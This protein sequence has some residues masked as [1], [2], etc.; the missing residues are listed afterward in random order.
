MDP[1]RAPN[2]P[3]TTRSGT[4]CAAP[5][6]NWNCRTAIWSRFQMP[7]KCAFHPTWAAVDTLPGTTGR[8]RHRRCPGKFIPAP[9][10]LISLI[11]SSVVTSEMQFRRPAETIDCTGRRPMLTGG[12]IRPPGCPH[13]G[14]G[15]TQVGPGPIRQITTLPKNIKNEDICT[16]SFC[17]CRVMPKWCWATLLDAQM[18]L[19]VLLKAQKQSWGPWK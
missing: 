14:A 9:A 2:R 18:L 19:E 7:S 6:P 10:V 13:R 4:A 8:I 3:Q 15:P 11:P 12:D 5:A 16:N 17:A 1:D